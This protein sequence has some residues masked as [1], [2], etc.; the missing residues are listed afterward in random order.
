MVLSNMLY[1]AQYKL[2]NY[3]VKANFSKGEGAKRWA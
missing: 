1:T 3:T 2:H